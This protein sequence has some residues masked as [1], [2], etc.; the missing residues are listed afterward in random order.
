MAEKSNTIIE[1]HL[2]SLIVFNI[3]EFSVMKKLQD[4]IIFKHKA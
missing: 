1:L 2:N 3:M 4:N